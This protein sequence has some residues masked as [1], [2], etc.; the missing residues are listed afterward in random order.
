MMPPSTSVKGPAPGEGMVAALWRAQAF[1]KT[2]LVTQDGRALQVVF[3]GR[4]NPTAGPDFSGAL[5]AKEGSALTKGD[6]E[7]HV[8]SRDWRLHGHDADPRYNQVMLHVV[9]WDSPGGPALRQDG[10]AVP[11][12]ALASRI[13][14]PLELLAGQARPAPLLPEPCRTALEALGEEPVGRAL[15]EAGDAWLQ[16]KALLMESRID[17]AGPEQVLYEGLMEALG[18]SQNQQPFLALAR[19]VPYHALEAAT[20]GAHRPLA[21][22]QALLLG[23]G[24]F[25]VSEGQGLPWE[26][27]ALA[28]EVRSAWQA[29]GDSPL[30]LGWSAAHGR[31][32]NHPALRL[33]GAAALLLQHR[34]A[35]LIDGMRRALERLP[36]ALVVS[37]TEARLAGP[38]PIGKGRALEAAANVLCP[39]YFALGRSRRQS[40][41]CEEAVTAF[42]RLPPVPTNH[43]TR[44]M[45]EQVLGRA[46]H[47]LASG[48]RRQ[49]GLLHLY[50]DRCA[51]LRCGGCALN[52]ARTV[53][54]EDSSDSGW[55]LLREMAGVYLAA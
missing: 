2:G 38:A 35:G 44:W 40:H 55:G 31:P 20:M 4:P 6:V 9:L 54:G 27:A 47:P 19:A 46:G 30:D 32:G 50:K 12:L 51:E 45:E 39:F 37:A 10:E 28:G 48:A 14:Q 1:E 53:A 21:M 23:Y 26:K 3:P 33:A 43:I 25:L 5:L 34:N 41:M 17:M 22:L 42:H 18:Y 49:Q 16:R 29:W 7:V 8:R 52:P 24:G 15:E 13:A 11:T 36:E